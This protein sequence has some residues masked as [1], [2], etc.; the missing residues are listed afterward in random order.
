MGSKKKQS[1][2]SGIDLRSSR[3]WRLPKNQS[4]RMKKINWL[5][6][7]AVIPPLIFNSMEQPT[8]LGFAILN[9]GICLAASRMRLSDAR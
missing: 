8:Y 7:P 1:G 5:L 2:Q 6:L 4:I 9:A 3:L